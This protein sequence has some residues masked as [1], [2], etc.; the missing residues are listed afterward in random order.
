[1]GSLLVR[2]S[3]GIDK[4]N[5]GSTYFGGVLQ[6]TFMNV[7]GDTSPDVRLDGVTDIVVTTGPGNDIISADG[8]NGTTGVALDASIQFSAYGGVGDDTL[9]G[10]GAVAGVGPPQSLLFGGPGDDKF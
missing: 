1:T 8:G 2:G 6:D 10:G 7:N 4:V 9:T 3:S 5:L